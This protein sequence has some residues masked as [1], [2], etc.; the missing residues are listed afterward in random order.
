MNHKHFGPF[1]RNWGEKRI[2]PQKGKY[3]MIA[4]MTTT[5]LFTIWKT[6]NPVAV[7]G[8]A[9]VMILVATWAWRFPGSTEEWQRRKDNNEK[10]GWIK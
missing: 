9:A 10:I 5:V 4:V 3:L 8:T 2:F 7:I 1:L 6:M